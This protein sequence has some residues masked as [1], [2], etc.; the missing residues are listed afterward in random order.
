MLADNSAPNMADCLANFYFVHLMGS[1]SWVAA[2][3]LVGLE[4]VEM[5]ETQKETGNARKHKSSKISNILAK[6]PFH[7]S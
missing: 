1:D 5:L 2:D 6:T 4:I 3:M 7:R